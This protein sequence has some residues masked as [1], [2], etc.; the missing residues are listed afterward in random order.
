M[1]YSI[2][3]QMNFLWEKMIL[4]R[5]NSAIK[6]KTGRVMKDVFFSIWNLEIP[7]SVCSRTKRGVVFEC[8]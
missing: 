3:W 1:E 6:V 4:D 5:N 8:I 2:E 7:H